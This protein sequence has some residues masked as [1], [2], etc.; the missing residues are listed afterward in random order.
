MKNMKYLLFVV[1][2]LLF[3]P[4]VKANSIN[5]IDVKMHIDEYGNAKVTEVWDMYIDEGTEVYK[6]LGDMENTELSNFKVSLDGKEFTYL[7]YW[8][9][10]DSFENKAYKNGISSSNELC[11]GQSKR[12]NN[13]YTI[14]YDLTNVI[15]NVDDAQFL[16]W[17]FINDNMNPAPKNISITIDSF[18]SYPETLDVW[19]Y[20]YKGYAYVKDGVI[21]ASNEDQFNSSMYSVLLVKYPTGTY[22]TTNKVE[23]YNTFDEIYNMAE[24]NTFDYDY[25]SDNNGFNFFSIVF[26]IF[27]FFMFFLVFAIGIKASLSG[28]LALY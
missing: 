15:Y 11:F 6:P 14:T 13:V 25:D 22:N 17:K 19:G 5:S 26:A 3:I 12:G 2:T 18:Y 9:I 24:N 23:Y 21:S 4:N 10:N 20:G 1:F 28:S 8:N 27:P 16:Y 7:D